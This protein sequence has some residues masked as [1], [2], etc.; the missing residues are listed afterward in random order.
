MGRLFGL[1]AIALVAAPLSAFAAP[2]LTP[3]TI[4]SIFGT[5]I[6]FV[7][8]EVGGQTYNLVLRRDGTATRTSQGTKVVETGAW[9]A[10]DSGYCAKWGTSPEQ[11]YSIERVDPI[12]Y[13]VFDSSNKVIAHWRPTL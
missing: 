6:A 9:R 7:D 2:K 1:L 3:A 11:C 8:A 10:A 12:T 13:D 5:G 4:Q